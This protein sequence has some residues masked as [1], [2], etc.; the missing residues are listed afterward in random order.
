MLKTTCS[1]L[2]AMNLPPMRGRRLL[3]HGGLT[4]ISCILCISCIL[5]IYS[6]PYIYISYVI[7]IYIHMYSYIYIFIYIYSNIYIYNYLYLHILLHIFFYI[8]QRMI[9]NIPKCVFCFGATH[10]CFFVVHVPR[11]LHG[12]VPLPLLHCHAIPSRVLPHLHDS[13]MFIDT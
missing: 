8:Y 7:C 2:R 10:W 5:F 3:L 9:S 11:H 12:H 4:S 6:Y 13:L 1:R